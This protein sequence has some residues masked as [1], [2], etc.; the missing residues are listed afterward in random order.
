LNSYQELVRHLYGNVIILCHHNADPDAICAAYAI[1]K[2]IHHLNPKTFVEVITPDG[3]SKLSEKVLEYTELQVSKESLMGKV[4]TVIVVDTGSLKQLEQWA[5]RFI[6]PGFEKIVID[7][8]TPDPEMQKHA[9][10]YFNDPESIATCEI[11]FR[12]LKELNTPLDETLATALLVGILFDSRQ[13]AI[14]TPGT[15]RV[16][17]ELAEVGATMFKAKELLAS[18]MDPSEKTARLKAAQ[19][20]KVHRIES[21]FVATSNLSSFQSSAARAFLALGADVSILVGKDK[22]AIQASFR[23]TDDFWKKTHIDLG[24]ISKILA[25]SFKGTGGGHPTAAG[26]NGEGEEKEFLDHALGIITARLNSKPKVT[27]V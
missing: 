3:A 12:I 22:N 1:K 13:F 20:M 23:S 8:H 26:V 14:A 11:V 9:T 21:W 18:T 24:E 7:H 4:D 19:R 16:A 2:M 10:F 6:E 27:H 15:F 5:L 17:A 25:E